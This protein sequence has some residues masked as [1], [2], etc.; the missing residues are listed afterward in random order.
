VWS[1]ADIGADTSKLGAAGARAKLNKLFVP[2][3]EGVCEIIEGE[4]PE[5]AAVALALKLREVRL[6]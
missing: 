2:V 3:K 1:A 4:S 5:E 6:I